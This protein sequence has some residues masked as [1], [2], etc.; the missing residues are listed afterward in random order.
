MYI[1]IYTLHNA[2][3]YIHI[4]IY[5]YIPSIIHNVYQCTRICMY[6]YI[7][8]FNLYACVYVI[9]IDTVMCDIER[10]HHSD[11]QWTT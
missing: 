8:T 2:P 5:R 11:W 7:H 4:Y 1:Y 9:C 6:I 10:K 3:T